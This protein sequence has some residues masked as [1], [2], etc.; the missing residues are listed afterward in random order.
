M[1][2]EE[3]K[4]VILHQIKEKG[5]VKKNSYKI[6]VNLVLKKEIKINCDIKLVCHG[7]SLL[8]YY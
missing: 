1:T 8:Y 7:F 5:M 4:N 6:M 3:G 2:K